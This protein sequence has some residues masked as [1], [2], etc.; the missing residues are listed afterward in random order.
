MLDTASAVAG[1]RTVEACQ[2]ALCKSGGSGVFSS[3]ANEAAIVVHTPG[4]AVDFLIA[5]LV[6]Q[7]RPALE[8][9]ELKTIKVGA[10]DHIDYTCDSV[11]T[12]YRGSA[13]QKYVDS[14]DQRSG[15]QVEVRITRCTAHTSRRQAASVNH[16]ER[17]P[18][19]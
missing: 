16:H 1:I 18:R 5:A 6:G 12:V 14:L 3:D 2:V 13:V 15:Y 7:T 11:G 19:I 4:G 8:R 9:V 10:Q 17:T